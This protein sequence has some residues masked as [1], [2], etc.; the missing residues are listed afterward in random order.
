MFISD[1]GVTMIT[2]NASMKLTDKICSCEGFTRPPECC[3]SI[4]SIHYRLQ[5]VDPVC[6]V[7]ANVLLVGTH[8]EKLHPDL[9]Q[10]LIITSNKILPVFEKE[11]FRKPYTQHLAGISKCLEITL[12]KSC[13]FVSNKCRDEEIEQ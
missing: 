7:K 11:L 13:F 1:S 6:S 3:T 8:T 5:V 4:S 10:A 2:F 12:K 9:K